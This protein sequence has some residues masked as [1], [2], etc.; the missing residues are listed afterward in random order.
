MRPA[1]ERGRF[2]GVKPLEPQQRLRLRTELMAV[3]RKRSARVTGFKKSCT[4]YYF[5]NNYNK[6]ENLSQKHPIKKFGPAFQSGPPEAFIFSEMP[7]RGRKSTGLQGVS[8]WRENRRRGD[9]EL[10]NAPEL[11]YKGANSDFVIIKGENF[12]R[13]TSR[14]VQSAPEVSAR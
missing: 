8:L 7:S 11:T 1:W 14:R 12:G 13:G 2:L 10:K 5:V 6:I 9:Y 3:S 4:N